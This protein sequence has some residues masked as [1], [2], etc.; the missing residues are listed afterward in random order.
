MLY[1]RVLIC[2]DDIGRGTEEIYTVHTGATEYIIYRVHISCEYAL[3]TYPAFS[4][5]K[6]NLVTNWHAPIFVP[7]I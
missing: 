6:I 2:S 4:I 1:L 5:I 3:T 7:A